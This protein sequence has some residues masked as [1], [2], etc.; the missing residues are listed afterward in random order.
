VIVW[1]LIFFNSGIRKDISQETYYYYG[2]L[3][4]DS[5]KIEVLMNSENPIHI[6]HTLVDKT[7]I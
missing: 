2:A 5:K 4:K 6:S 1:L 3:L 7:E